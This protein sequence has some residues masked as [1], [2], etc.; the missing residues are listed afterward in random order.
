MSAWKSAAMAVPRIDARD[1]ARN[2]S[3]RSRVWR[4]SSGETRRIQSI[5]A[6]ALDEEEVERDEHDRGVEGG[7]RPT[8]PP[9]S[10]APP[11]ATVE[12]GGRSRRA[13]SR[14][15]C[16]APSSLIEQ[17]LGARRQVAVAQ[18]GHVLDAELVAHE[19]EPLD[20][21]RG[22]EGDD[23]GERTDDAARSSDSVVATPATARRP[24]I[25]RVIQRNGPCSTLASTAARSS[26]ARKGQMT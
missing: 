16:S 7:A 19:G 6:A 23:G 20:H 9:P 10:T 18:L 2:S 17:L 13:A 22:G 3:R 21:L 24:R 5:D 14:E 15:T 25:R 8:T 12:A 1:T 26:G 4:A 11:S